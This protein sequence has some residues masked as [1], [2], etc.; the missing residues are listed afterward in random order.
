MIGAASTEHITQGYVCHLDAVSA[1]LCKSAALP[2]N[3]RDRV[4]DRSPIVGTT[5]LKLVAAGGGLSLAFRSAMRRVRC[6]L[7][8]HP[9][10]A[11]ETRG[12]G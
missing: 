4:M 12:H 10:S 11:I 7:A 9:N 5:A 2:R 6:S 3:G 8:A 1:A